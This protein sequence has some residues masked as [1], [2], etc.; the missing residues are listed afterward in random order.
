MAA[1]KAAAALAAGRCGRALEV[2][3]RRHFGRCHSAIRLCL[4][5]MSNA[6][7]DEPRLS[8]P[9]QG[10]TFRLTAVSCSSAFSYH[11]DL[12]GFGVADE[13]AFQHF[14]RTRNIREKDSE[15]TGSA[16]FQ[17]EHA[18]AEVLRTR[19]NELG[20]VHDKR[21][22]SCAPSL[23]PD[24][25]EVATKDWNKTRPSRERRLRLIG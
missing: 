15:N 20:I 8:A 21:F 4:A 23:R 11:F 24:V 7:L 17:R 14:C 25:S 12:E 6:S 3:S 10:A 22:R 19:D 1:D 18:Y 16:R 5:N 2:R 9:G 13:P